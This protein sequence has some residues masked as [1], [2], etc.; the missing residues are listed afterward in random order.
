[1]S[2]S[3]K[4]EV[5][6]PFTKQLQSLFRHT[7]YI[8]IVTSIQISSFVAT[9]STKIRH[10]LQFSICTFEYTAPCKLSSEQNES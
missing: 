10:D 1:M 5:R 4:L 7:M 9:N 6:H 3:I 8:T 2:L